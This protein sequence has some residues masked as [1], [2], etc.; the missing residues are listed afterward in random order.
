MNPFDPLRALRVLRA[1]R[2]R[3]VLIGGI[4]ARLQ[5]SP[6]VTNDLDI[7][8][9]RTDEDLERLAAAL[10]ELGAKLRGVD[11]DVPFRPDAATLRAGD[12]FTFTTDAGAL[13]CLGTPAGSDGYG[14]LAR[15]AVEMDLDGLPV[16]V[17]SLDD[18]LAMKAAAGRPKDLIELEVLH[19]LQDERDGA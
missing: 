12:H 13:D 10:T 6:T 14:S 15:G 16:L 7:C 17:A 5:G 11:E 2:V 19:A 18:L 8:Y 1:H 4:G 3:F 9:A